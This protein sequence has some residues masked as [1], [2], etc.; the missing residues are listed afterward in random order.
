MIA[1]GF[2]H[3]LFL[4]K[5]GQIL[6]CGNNSQK[7]LNWH[8]D[9]E[10]IFVPEILLLEERVTKIYASEFSAA[11][12]DKEELLLWGNFGGKINPIHNPL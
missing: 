1:S 9:V 3:T 10:W 11:V 2:E 4:N 6:V 12:T 8:F 5:N 7:Q